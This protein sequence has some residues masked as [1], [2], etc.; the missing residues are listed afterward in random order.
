MEFHNFFLNV[1]VFRQT[2]FWDENFFSYLFL[3]VLTF[4]GF[5]VIFSRQIIHFPAVFLT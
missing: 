3:E 1:C 5:T 4:G 2:V